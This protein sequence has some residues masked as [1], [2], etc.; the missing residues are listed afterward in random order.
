MGN[1]ALLAVIWFCWHFKGTL[2]VCLTVSLT[3]VTIYRYQLHL[4]ARAPRQQLHCSRKGRFSST[5]DAFNLQDTDLGCRDS[6]SAGYVEFKKSDVDPSL[7]EELLARHYTRTG[8]VFSTNVDSQSPCT[9]EGFER[10]VNYKLNSISSRTLSL[11]LTCHVTFMGM[12]VHV[13]SDQ[14]I[15][16]KEVPVITPVASRP[17]RIWRASKALM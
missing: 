9:L 4:P 14:R 6:R 12:L 8:S 5:F 16:R 13:M 10:T 11:S 3:F 1:T 17:M 2:C 15:A 7:V